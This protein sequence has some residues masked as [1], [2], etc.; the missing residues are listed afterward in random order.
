VQPEPLEVGGLRPVGLHVARDVVRY[1]RQHF[2]EDLAPVLH[3][4]HVAAI[5]HLPLPRAAQEAV[6]VAD[7]VGELRRAAGGA[8]QEMR[9][10]REIGAFDQDGRRH[11]A[12]DE[13]TVAVA[14][15]EMGR[16]DL[17]VHD[18]R[19]F[20]GARADH[21][22]G[23]LDAEGGRG[24]GDVHV[25]AEAARAEQLLDLHRDGGVGAFVVGGG[26]KD[27][28][29][30]ARRHAGHGERGIAGLQRHFGHLPGLVIGPFAQPRVHHV[31][32]QHAGLVEHVALF[33][34]RGGDDEFG[35]GML[36]LPRPRPRRSA[37]RG[38]VPAVG[39][40]VEGLDKLIVRDDLGRR[41]DPVP[42]DGGLMHVSL[43]GG[44]C[45]DGGQSRARS[46]LPLDGREATHTVRPCCFWANQ[47]PSVIP[48]SRMLRG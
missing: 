42:G 30:L 10:L 2:L 23:G 17:G 44:V 35:R 41:E 1:Q 20:D 3:E 25:E 16:A 40:G 13:V 31:G 21:V 11:V 46:R 5:L 36:A 22:G 37:G 8:D 43:P 45:A 18:Q 38:L 12:E 28:V 7:V 39:I 29:D 47:P 26:A 33:D 9:A 4:L 19:A 6:V 24:T 34:A 15:F 14:P 48:W 27:G 32:V